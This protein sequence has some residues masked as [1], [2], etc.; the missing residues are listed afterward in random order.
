L[1][2]TVP[3]RLAMIADRL[4]GAVGAD[5]RAKRTGFERDVDVVQDVDLA[6]AGAQAADLEQRH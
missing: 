5:D 4:A 1:K 3:A 2:Y 6:V